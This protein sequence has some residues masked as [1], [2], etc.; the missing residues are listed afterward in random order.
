MAEKAGVVVARV[1]GVNWGACVWV[2]KR[3]GILETSV[4]LILR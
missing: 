1:G 4:L 3:E 2:E